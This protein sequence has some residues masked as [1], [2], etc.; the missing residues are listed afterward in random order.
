MK[1]I[2]FCGNRFT[3]VPALK[4]LLKDHDVYFLAILNSH[5]HKWLLDQ[6]SVRF[7]IVSDKRS[8]DRFIDRFSYDIL[9]TNGCPFIVSEHHLERKADKVH[10]NLHPSPLPELRGADPIPGAILFNRNFGATCHKMSPIIDGGDIISQQVIKNTDTEFASEM[11]KNIFQTERLVLTE[12]VER[13][14]LPQSSQVLKSENVYYSFNPQDNIVRCNDDSE[15]I[16]RKFRAFDNWN[17]GLWIENDGKLC[18]I[19]EIQSTD[20]DVRLKL[21]LNQVRDLTVIPV[22]KGE[23]KR[24]IIKLYHRIILNVS[25][26]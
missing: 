24:L 17:K 26:Y 9:I 14:F 2:L 7:S 18:R 21:K 5:L 12:A 23:T 15:V 19:I 22:T 6:S 8:F 4:P 1:Q 16:Y 3:S 11:Y 20:F 13:N 25:C 10:V